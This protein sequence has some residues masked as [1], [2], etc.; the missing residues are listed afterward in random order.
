MAEKLDAPK[1]C[2]EVARRASRKVTPSELRSCPTLAEKW[3]KRRLALGAEIMAKVGADIDQ[4]LGSDFGRCSPSLAEFGPE[5]DDSGPSLAEIGSILG[6]IGQFPSIP[7]EILP[8]LADL[9]P[10]IIII[11]TTIINR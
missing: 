8:N 6:D 10:T 3:W 5:L 9:R 4:L 11:I 2:G 7:G 1:G